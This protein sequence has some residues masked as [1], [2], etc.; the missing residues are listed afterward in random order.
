MTNLD[1][2]NKFL[3]SGNMGKIIILA[4]PR[5]AITPDEALT[6]AGWLVAL[7]EPEVGDGEFQKRLDAILST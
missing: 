7:A 2:T 6:L 1:I 3:V 5:Q 4:P